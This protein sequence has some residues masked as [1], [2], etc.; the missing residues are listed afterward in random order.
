MATASSSMSAVHSMRRRMRATSCRSHS[1]LASAV[2]GVLI[3]HPHQ[4]HYGLL[5]DVP[6]G[7]PIYCGAAT[8]RLIRLS[9]AIFG[10][11]LPHAF[12]PWKSGVALQI[13]P[14][15]IT[16]FLIDHSAFDAYMMLIEVHGK[17]VL[18]SGDFRTHGRKSVLTRRL[19][20]APPENIDVLL[21]E[22]TNLGSDKPCITES[23]LEDD[24]VD[25]F[26][27]TA[28][29]V[30][31]AWS[32]QNVDRTVT[33]YRACLKAGRT[34]VVDLYTAEVM[35]ALAEFRKAAAARLEESEGGCHQR[36]C[37]DVST[38]RP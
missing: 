36:V 32:A 11:E 6:A 18:Y 7:W 38:D 2:D 27:S 15:T 9:S 20:A 25:L 3:S 30:F 26:R 29:R 16:P 4:D 13:G 33:L 8:E 37:P 22:G 35:E 31:V 10:K 14:F 28:G 24:F 23:D 5:E 12:H 1:N 17:R 19:M 21:M 34:L